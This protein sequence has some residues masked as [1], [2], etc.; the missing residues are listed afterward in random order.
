MTGI[1]IASAA[2]N[3]C[4]A[5]RKQN[6]YIITLTLIDNGMGS[7]VINHTFVFL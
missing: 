6:N 4:Y 7:M 3:A 5:M 2:F 1:I